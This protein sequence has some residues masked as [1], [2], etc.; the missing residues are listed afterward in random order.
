MRLISHVDIVRS[1]RA[2]WKSNPHIYKC[3]T[4]LHSDSINSIIRFF[5]GYHQVLNHQIIDHHS[6]SSSDVV[7]F[8]FCIKFILFWI[9]FSSSFEKID[10]FRFFFRNWIL[11]QRR[12]RKNSF[13]IKNLFSFFLQFQFFFVSFLFC[14]DCFFICFDQNKFERIQKTVLIHF[15]LTIWIS[16]KLL[17]SFAV[18]LIRNTFMKI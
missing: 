7:L 8:L 17:L 18:S 9:S 11:V 10:D 14:F 3:Y 12:N 16:Q 6:I 4:F 2:M 15:F 5:A 1:I 13:F